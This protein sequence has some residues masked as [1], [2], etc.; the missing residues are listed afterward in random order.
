MFEQLIEPTQQR[1]LN[2]GQQSTYAVSDFLIHD[3]DRSS[4]VFFVLDGLL[5]VVKSSANGRVS[6]VAL[7]GSG[8]IVG[9]LGLLS[10]SPRAGS[11]QAVN[12]TTVVYLTESEFRALLSECPDFSSAL[13]SN[14]ASRLQ[15]A[16]DQIHDLMSVDAVTRLAG[17]LVLLAKESSDVPRSIGSTLGLDLP[18]SQQ[19]V[20]E[21]AGL[22]RAATGKALGKLR[23]LGLINTGRM[24]MQIND[25][26]R[27]TA[28]AT[29]QTQLSR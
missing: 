16:T 25:L 13:L 26:A 24:S 1:I 9:D 19:E 7:R 3:G 23:E 21:W 20:G 18:I 10:P 29:E 27:L 14:L 17:R 8:S 28:I 2:T 12:K 4:Q 6:F 11:I 22:S 5:K 15:E